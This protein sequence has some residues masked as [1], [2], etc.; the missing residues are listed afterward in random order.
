[1]GLVAAAAVFSAG[2]WWGRQV[3]GK[4]AVTKKKNVAANAVATKA[5]ISPQSVTAPPAPPADVLSIELGSCAAP[6]TTTTA[7]KL[8]ALPKIT[9]VRHWSSSLES[10]VGIFM[11]DQLPYKVPPFMLPQPIYFRLPAPAL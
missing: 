1:M 4:T 2:V 9:G 7:N 6:L 11:D 5:T 8:A 3:H 10:T